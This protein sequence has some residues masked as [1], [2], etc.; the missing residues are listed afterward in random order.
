[1]RQRITA[2]VAW[3]RARK[4]ERATILEMKGGGAVEMKT[5]AEAAA[6]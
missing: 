6:S 3:N 5:A 4:D 2:D 1:M